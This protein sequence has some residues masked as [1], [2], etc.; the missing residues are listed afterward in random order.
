MSG[1]WDVGFCAGNLITM[2]VCLLFVSGE[3]SLI[4]LYVD[5][6]LLTCYIS[7]DGNILC[8]NY[9]EGLIIGLV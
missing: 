8:H 1:M 2:D 7:R 5:I 6:L 4:K 9:I 3:R